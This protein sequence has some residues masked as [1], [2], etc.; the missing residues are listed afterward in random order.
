MSLKESSYKIA[1]GYIEKISADITKEVKDNFLKLIQDIHDGKINT[2]SKFYSNLI[3]IGI[4]KAM[5]KDII[6]D[7]LSTG[8][9]EEIVKI[10]YFLGEGKPLGSKTESKGLKILAES[11]VKRQ[12]DDS[13]LTSKILPLYWC[14]FRDKSWLIEEQKGLKK[15]ENKENY[16]TT[17]NRKEIEEEKELKENK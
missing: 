8:K 16:W 7:F 10:V 15:E 1:M 9:P 17:R 2:P 5:L 6:L 14:L 13:E 11:W 4:K 12:F 3:A